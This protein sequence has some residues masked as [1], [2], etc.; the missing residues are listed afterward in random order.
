MAPVKDNH[1]L[2][3]W[4]KGTR[5]AMSPEPSVPGSV[6][7]ISKGLWTG[8]WANSDPTDFMLQNR[9]FPKVIH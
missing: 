9:I 7:S 3:T 5:A 2:K 6:R 4:A 1:A 8:V